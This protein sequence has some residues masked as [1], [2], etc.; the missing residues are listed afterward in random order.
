LSLFSFQV[1]QFQITM[2]L[3]K[4]DRVLVAYDS[5]TFACYRRE[6]HTSEIGGARAWLEKLLEVVSEIL[7]RPA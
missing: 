4:Q 2:P 3:Q 1:L 7:P 5:N 6:Q